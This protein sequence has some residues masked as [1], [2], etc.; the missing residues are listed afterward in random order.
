MNSTTKAISAKGDRADQAALAKGS[1]P[2]GEAADAAI[3]EHDARKA[4][5][6]DQRGEG[7]DEARQAK[8]GHEPAVE[9]ARPRRRWSGRSG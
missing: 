2:I 8:A 9:Q 7:D 1:E 6:A 4:T 5:K 3:F